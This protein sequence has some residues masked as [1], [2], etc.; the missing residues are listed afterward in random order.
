MAKTKAATITD[1]AKAADVSLGTVSRVLNNYADVNAE[2]R[3][4]V[5]NAAREL[6]YTRL[7]QRRSAP[8]APAAPTQLGN[9][10]IIIFGME[11]TL[12]H[13]PVIGAALQGIEHALA[14]LGRNIMIANVPR[15]DRVP[16][17]L[18]EKRVD[19][20]ILKGPNQGVLPPEAEC[21][22]LA[23][24][25]RIPH[26]WL[27][28][29]LENA[30]GD[31][32]NFDTTVATRLVVQHFRDKGHRRLGFLNPKPGQTQFERLKTGFMA[33]AD[34]AGCEATILESERRD[35]LVWP[36]PATTQ[37][38]NVNTLVDRWIKLPVKTRPT[39]LFV[40]S[41]RAAVQLYSA[42]ERRRL[43]AGVDVSVVSCNNEMSLVMD[44][45]PAPTAI[46]VHA[47]FIGRRTVDQLLWRMRHPDE[48]LSV[49]VLVEPTLVERDSVVTLDHA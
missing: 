12:A 21:E 23:H 28:G 32:C 40:P 19:G 31:H 47:D 29:R 36:L 35:P 13:L 16:P 44:L 4:R 20:L 49:E 30:R 27:M 1:V 45:N 22:L 38:G 26:V 24:V 41:D 34:R 46:D 17:F 2:I 11:D 39:A 6:N 8:A 7:R 14:G 43:R 18:A 15:G 5:L 48:P 3:A 33:C 25:Y 37:Q 9:I 10:A 42:L